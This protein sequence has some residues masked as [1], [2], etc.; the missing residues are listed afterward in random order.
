MAKALCAQLARLY[1]KAGV[2]SRAA[3]A[4]LLAKYLLGEPSTWAEQAIG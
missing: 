3:F 4:G 1:H 2:G